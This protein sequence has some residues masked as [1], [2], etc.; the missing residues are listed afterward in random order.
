MTDI[1]KLRT[2]LMRRFEFDQ[3]IHA[4]SIDDEIERW[5]KEMEIGKAPPSSNVSYTDYVA[6]LRKLN[7]EGA[8]DDPA[9]WG[10]DGAMYARANAAVAQEVQ[11]IVEEKRKERERLLLENIATTMFPVHYVKWDGNT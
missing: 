4:S 2:A 5:M 7:T 1:T 11:R 9:R 8:D 6:Y 10:S 3:C